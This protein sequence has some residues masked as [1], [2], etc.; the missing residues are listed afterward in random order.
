MNTTALVPS[1]RAAIVARRSAALRQLF[2]D[3]GLLAFS[4]AV[5]ACSPRTAAD[6]LSLLPPAQRNAVL[7]HM[8]SS[9]RTD[10]A[11]AALLASLHLA[12]AAA[13][14]CA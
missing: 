13:G 9:R 12:R 11:F 1:L 5:T 4:N 2:D 7:R 8:P 6:A 14:A 10:P 3:H